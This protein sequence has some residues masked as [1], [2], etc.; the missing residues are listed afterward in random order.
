M[1]VAA[2]TSVV[3]LSNVLDVCMGQTVL[4]LV[5]VCN[6]ALFRNAKFFH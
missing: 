4:M 1:S 5:D 2:R 3:I 6:R